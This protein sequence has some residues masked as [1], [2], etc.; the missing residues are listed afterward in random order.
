MHEV[1]N[2]SRLLDSVYVRGYLRR[3][4][5]AALFPRMIILANV[6]FLIPVQTAIVER[7]FSVYRIVK[8][9]LSDRI[10]SVTLDSFLRIELL[11][12]GH[13]TKSMLESFDSEAAVAAH[14]CVPVN[15]REDMKRQDNEVVE[16]EEDVGARMSKEEESDGDDGKDCLV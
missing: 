12:L 9:R 4:P 2:Q 15:S 6:M 5:D 13:E 7:G 10:T 14:T 3:Q 8:S 11:K 1:V 16:E